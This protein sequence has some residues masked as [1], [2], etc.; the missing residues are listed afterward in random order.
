MSEDVEELKRG[1]A[2]SEIDHPDSAARSTHT[3]ELVSDAA[4][5]RSEHRATARRDDVEFSVLEWQRFCVRLA[6]L[7]LDAIRRGRA[8]AGFEI[9]RREV[10]CHDG[11]PALSRANRDVAGAGSDIEHTVASGDAARLDEHWAELPHGCLRKPV[12]VAERP[13]LPMSRLHLADR[14]GRQRAV[15]RF[16]CHHATNVRSRRGQ[17]P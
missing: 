8:A 3:Q 1:T 11:G 9:R 15:Q 6:P 12:I 5:V 13:H 17:T 16:A 10:R 7:E 14:I 4:V 2:R